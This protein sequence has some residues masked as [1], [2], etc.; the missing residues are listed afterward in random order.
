[1]NAINLDRWP[2]VDP[3]IRATARR[4]WNIR[5]AAQLG[6]SRCEGCWIVVPEHAPDGSA[7]CEGCRT[8]P[9]PDAGEAQQ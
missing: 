1:M 2:K 3:A 7:L 5:V 8:T 4:R 9:L 6:Y